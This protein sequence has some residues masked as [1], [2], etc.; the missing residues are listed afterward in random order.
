MF[1]VGCPSNLPSADRFLFQRGSSLRLGRNV[2]DLIAMES[3]F[4]SSPSLKSASQNSSETG[5]G[6][7]LMLCVT[8]PLRRLRSVFRGKNRPSHASLVKVHS[9]RDTVDMAQIQVGQQERSLD[10]NSP[11]LLR[12]LKSGL[13]TL[14]TSPLETEVLQ[15]VKN[16]ERHTSLMLINGV[17]ALQEQILLSVMSQVSASLKEATNSQDQIRTLNCISDIDRFSIS[18]PAQQ[19]PS[20]SESSVVRSIGQ[21]GRISPIIQESQEQNNI[22]RNLT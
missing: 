13:D 8:A 17:G 2:T 11:P 10:R 3:S 22:L 9:S 1:Q 16:L 6:H 12:S 15:A 4:P 21:C 5:D 18:R 19:E 14:P 7:C 20:V